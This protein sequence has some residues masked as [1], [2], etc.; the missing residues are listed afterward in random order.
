MKDFVTNLFSTFLGAILAVLVLIFTPQISERFAYLNPSCDNPEGLS[1]LNLK[2][3]YEDKQL[4]IQT[5]SVVKPDSGYDSD[6]YEADKV[7]DGNPGRPWVPAEE[8]RKRRLT[9]TFT[10]R[11]RN[12]QLICIVNGQASDSWSYLRAE[13]IRTA[14]VYTHGNDGVRAPVRTLGEYDLQNRQELRF[15]EGRT[16]M[17]AIE[18]AET[19]E[20]RTVMD[21]DVGRYLGPKKRV[22]FGEIELYVKDS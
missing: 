21:P 1:S 9:L 10:D 3:M 22:A 4:L 12:V 13:R 5:T 16:K 8:D 2:Q 17:V 14:Y 11:E 20:G 18:I 6:L 15:D 19:Y 7:I